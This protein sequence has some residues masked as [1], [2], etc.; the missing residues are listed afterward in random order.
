MTL[1]ST[2]YI[3]VVL[4]NSVADLPACWEGLQAQTYPQ[5]Q[6][7]FFD[8]ASQDGSA[9]WAETHAQGAKVLRSAENL[10]FGRAHNRILQTLH[11]TPHDFYLA[12]N[13]DVQLTP[14][15]IEVLR[16]ELQAHSA[17]WGTGKLLLSSSSEPLIY[18]A[19]HALF[20]G[21]YALN[22]G[23]GLPD[24]VAFASSREVWGAPGAALLISGAFIQA[25]APDHLLFDER[26]F[27][28]YE[29]VELDWRARRAGGRCWYAAQAVAF[30]RGG[31]P[32]EALRGEALANR[33]LMVLKNAFYI[34]L[35]F[36]NLPLMVGH[37]MLRGI[38]APRTAWPIIRKVWRELGPRS[39]GP[40]TRAEWNQWVKW[41]G[42]QPSAQPRSLWARWRGYWQR[43]ETL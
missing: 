36:F 27:M 4:Y 12:L 41:A 39:G 15:Y 21:G 37:L 26:F 20:R 1:P 5:V 13:P 8:N 18:S 23:Y 6:V 30:H 38:L 31:Q 29:D 3:G 2:V 34:D 16:A 32:S 40:F 43:R 28:Y 24:G 7:I 35:L 10:G 9:T 14:T 11:L 42:Q 19:G 22:I 17:G 33:F 25:L